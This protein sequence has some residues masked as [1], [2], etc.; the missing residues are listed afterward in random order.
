[1]SRSVSSVNSTVT[2]D[3]PKEEEEEMERTPGTRPAAPSMRAVSS[4]SMVSGAAPEKSVRT[5]ITGLS[6]SGSSRI[7]AP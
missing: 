6:V 5:V 1:M 3:R 2:L 7:S 4:R